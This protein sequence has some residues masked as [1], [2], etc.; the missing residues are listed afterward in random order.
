VRCTLFLL[1]PV[2]QILLLL[3]L[4]LINANYSNQSIPTNHLLLAMV[5]VFSN[6]LL[7][8]KTMQTLRSSAFWSP[9]SLQ[10]RQK[11]Q[12][13]SLK[14]KVRKLLTARIELAKHATTTK[15]PD[16][17]LITTSVYCPP[18]RHKRIPLPVKQ[19][20]QQLLEKQQ[21]RRQLS[22]SSCLR[23]SCTDTKTCGECSFRL[24]KERLQ[25]QQ[26][27]HP[28]VRHRRLPLPLKKRCYERSD[29]HRPKRSKSPMNWRTKAKMSS[30]ERLTPVWASNV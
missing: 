7:W 1:N 20:L 2:L 18:V 19:R 30:Y 11:R 23:G 21:L 12:L 22:P 14:E 16:Q 10:D 8:R 5:F 13:Y 24:N 27:S 25:R 6:L 4:D 3:L 26:L 17:R 29:F 9:T 15:V 28:P